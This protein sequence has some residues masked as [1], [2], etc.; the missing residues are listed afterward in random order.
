VRQVARKLSYPLRMVK[1][2]STEEEGH[3]N[4]NAQGTRPARR[5][6]RGLMQLWTPTRGEPELLA[7]WGPLLMVARLARE[8]RVRWPVHIDQFDLLGR[9]D[10]SGSRR[11]VW[12]YRHHQSGGDIFADPTGQTYR[13]RPTPKAAGPGRFDRCDV[14]A[15]V[16][17]A[18]LPQV[19]PRREDEVDAAPLQRSDDERGS[20]M[21]A[22]PASRPRPSCRTVGL[23]VPRQERWL[24]AVP[25]M[26]A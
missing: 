13:Y 16:L 23:R 10:R 6:E 12:V 20:G 19:V 18:G 8:A 11:P 3:R 15:C 4:G 24:H 5:E 14:R 21:A 22:H 1:P 26:P 9:V 25:A 2:T 17:L 7:W